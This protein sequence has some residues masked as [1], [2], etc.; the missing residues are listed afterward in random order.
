MDKEIQEA[1]PGIT[2]VASASKKYNC[3]SYAWYSQTTS[4]P[5]WM[6]DPSAYMRDGSYKAGGYKKNNKI[7][8]ATL[9][10]EHSGV[11]DQVKVGMAGCYVTSKWGQYG[12]IRHFYNYCPYYTSSTQISLWERA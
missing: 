12:L 10:N 8:Y 2:L 1:Y 4:N 11:V 7:Y 6:N 9:G 3:H 5:Y